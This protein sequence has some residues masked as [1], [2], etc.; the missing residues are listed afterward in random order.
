[1]TDTLPRATAGATSS[2]PTTHMFVAS[3]V[4]VS[5]AT[6]AMP[7]SPGV[8]SSRYSSTPSKRRAT[9]IEVA[10]L[11]AVL[12][13]NRNASVGNA[14]RNA[15]MAF[16]SSSGAKTPPLS[17]RAPKP[18][19]STIQRAWSTMPEGSSAAPKRS[20]APPGCEAHL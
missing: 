7:V 18:N 11:Q 9:S 3:G 5:R 19:V 12:G 10:T 8:G 13:S 20:D 14:S 17:L 2:K 6:A 15:K 4:G 1:M 16:I